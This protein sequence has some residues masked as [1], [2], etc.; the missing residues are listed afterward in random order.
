[1]MMIIISFVVALGVGDE[2][3]KDDLR[4]QKIDC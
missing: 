3:Q 2:Q 4:S 1:M